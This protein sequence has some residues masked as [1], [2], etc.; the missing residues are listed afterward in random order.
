M[1]LASHSLQDTTRL[2]PVTPALLDGGGNARQ[3]E[4]HP[5]SYEDG[6]FDRAFGTSEWPGVAFT[7]FILFNDSDDN[8]MLSPGDRCLDHNVDLWNVIVRESNPYY[9]AMGLLLGHN[10]VERDSSG[11]TSM[12][13]ERPDAEPDLRLVTGDHPSACA[14]EVEGAEAPRRLEVCDDD[15][16]R[17][18]AVGK[19]DA[20]VDDN[21]LY[22]VGGEKEQGEIN[23]TL[24]KRH[25]DGVWQE[26]AVE[27][28]DRPGARVGFGAALVFDRIYV[29]GGRDPDDNDAPVT[30]VDVFDLAMR[31]WLREG[32]RPA[33]MGQPA[34]DVAGAVVS[35]RG[36]DRFFVLGPNVPRPDNQGEATVID[37]YD[38]T[39]GR[40]HSGWRQL[41]LPARRGVAATIMGGWLYAFGGVGDA[42]GVVETVER[43]DLQSEFFENLETSFPPPRVFAEAVTYEGEVYVIGGVEAEG[44]DAAS[45]SLQ[46]FVPPDGWTDMELP[47]GVGPLKYTNAV[48]F[49][50]RIYLLGGIDP[51]GHPIGL[52]VGLRLA[53]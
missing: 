11:S 8:Q 24:W 7:T 30:R 43:F 38:A 40:W 52:A 2:E 12:P 16:R 39:H 37:Y 28:Q 17:F 9:V 53:Q 36:D 50:R 35:E 47:N 27:P 42:H 41:A 44:N 33:D 4:L 18:P 48:V 19:G 22:Y 5:R 3:F 6:I 14:F 45:Q 10:L 1:E 29:V 34:T 51:D 46:R 49:D 31:R 23:M 26:I 20:V 25:R 21:H 32:E 13:F 15:P